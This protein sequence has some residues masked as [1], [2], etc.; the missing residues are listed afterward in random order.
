MEPRHTH[1]TVPRKKKKSGWRRREIFILLFFVTVS[2]TSF[3]EAYLYNQISFGVIKKLETLNSSTDPLISSIIVEEIIQ[4]LQEKKLTEGLVSFFPENPIFE[5]S[6]EIQRMDYLYYR[7]QLAKI[8]YDNLNSRLEKIKRRHVNPNPQKLDEEFLAYIESSPEVGEVFE[9][10]SFVIKKNEIDATLY[11]NGE[12]IIPKNLHLG[13]NLRLIISVKYLS[14]VGF[15]V[16][17]FWSPLH[18]L[19]KARIHRHILK[20]VKVAFT[21]WRK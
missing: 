5:V 20:M 18:I 8:Q 1:N 6:E 11:D 4:T 16:S 7:L 10:T 3:Y 17:F 15:S 2:F 14:L 12:A 21:T 19:A 13:N 9:E